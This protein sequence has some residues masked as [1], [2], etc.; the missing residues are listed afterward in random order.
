MRHGRRQQMAHD[1]ARKQRKT[2]ERS[3]AVLSGFA[4]ICFAGLLAFGGYLALVHPETPLP[5][6]WNP[7]KA[8]VISDPVTPLTA[9]KLNRAT[10]SPDQCLTT[11]AG[12]AVLDAMEPFE[13]TA[14]CY[15]R[16]RV[17]LRG[18]GAAALT[19]VETR[20]ATALRMTMW[21]YHSVQPAADW[22]FDMPVTRVSHIGSYNCRVMRTTSGPSARMSSHATADAIDITGFTLA[23]GTRIRLLADWSPSGPKAEFLREVRDG[24]CDWFSMTLSPDY[25]RLH[26]DHFHLQSSG[27]GFC[28]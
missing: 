14:Q 20:C 11:L 17:D 12:F 26:A 9:W 15:I 8:L 6:E 10:A 19:P 22:Y 2:K 27:W 21:E 13:D 5:R 28:R 24:A 4:A 16:D 1:A 25:N 23:D 18:V 7:T 3:T